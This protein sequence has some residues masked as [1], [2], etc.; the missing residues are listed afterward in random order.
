VPGTKGA[1]KSRR[2]QILKEA[3]RIFSEKTYHGTTLKDIA[4]AVGM[5]K[6]SLY[7]Y[8]SSKDKLLADIILEAAHTLNEEL[9]RVEHL[10]LDPI[11]RLRQIVKEHV[12]FNAIYREAGTLFLTEKN[13]I[14]SLE[15]GELMKIF[16]RRDRL[17]ARTLSEA[18]EKGLYRAVDIRITSLAIVGMCNSVLFWIKPSGRFSYEDVAETFFELIHDGLTIKA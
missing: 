13:A 17:L 14:S 18:I 8:I 12:K 1:K 11:E 6:G 9:V 2:E 10:K 15:M 16:G 5:L 4:D 3:T 7:H